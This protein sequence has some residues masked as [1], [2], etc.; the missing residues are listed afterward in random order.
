MFLYKHL[1]ES[2]TDKNIHKFG[3]VFIFM[4][5]SCIPWA[6]ETAYIVGKQGELKLS[7]ADRYSKMYPISWDQLH[8]DCRTLSW[9]LLDK[10][11]FKGILA[12]TRGGLVPAAILARELDIRLIDTVCISTYDW[13]TQEKKAT[14]LKNL[15]VMVKV[16]CW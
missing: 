14:V 15:K 3:D 7:K 4:L 1:C 8:K 6:R 13:K 9:Q 12:I 11:P 5:P 2:L 10:G 16:G